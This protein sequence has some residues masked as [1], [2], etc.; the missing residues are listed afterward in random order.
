M[1]RVL[2][3]GVFDLLHPGHIRLLKA[4]RKLGDQ[5]LVGLLYDYPVELRKGPD[6]PIQPYEDR[7]EILEALDCVWSVHGMTSFNPKG[8]L[9]ALDLFFGDDHY[10]TNSVSVVVHGDD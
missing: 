3:F 2:A 8:L 4:A 6:R 1:K 5:L 10:G 9:K 7:K